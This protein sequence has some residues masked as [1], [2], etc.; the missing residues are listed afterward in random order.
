MSIIK[1]NF[2]LKNLY[3][4]NREKSTISYSIL[5]LHITCITHYYYSIIFIIHLT[6]LFP[7][8]SFDKTM[9]ELP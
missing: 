2:M 6:A 9:D 8:T 4:I 7:T 3:T 1:S 5:L